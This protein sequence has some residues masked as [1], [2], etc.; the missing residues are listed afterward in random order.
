MSVGVYVDDHV[1]GVV[2]NDDRT[3]ICRVSRA[4][5]HAIHS[6]FPPPEV[7]GHTGGKDPISRKKLEKGDARFDVEKEILGFT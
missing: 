5:S 4:T 6:M 2:E 1:L 3:L 7:S